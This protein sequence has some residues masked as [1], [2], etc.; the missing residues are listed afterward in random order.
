[1]K[2]GTISPKYNMSCGVLI[3]AQCYQAEKE[4]FLVVWCPTRHMQVLG[5]CIFVVV[6]RM[7]LKPN[8]E[9]KKHGVVELDF[10]IEI[11]YY[12]IAIFGS[13]GCV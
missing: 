11:R 3:S 8:M 2:E 10:A 6:K 4:S 12:L 13:N 5:Q 7:L 9:L 1:M